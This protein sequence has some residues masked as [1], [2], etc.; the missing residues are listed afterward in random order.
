MR[1]YSPC[2]II[3]LAGGL[4][5]VGCQSIDRDSPPVLPAH[6]AKRIAPPSTTQPASAHSHLQPV[7]HIEPADEPPT[8]A[9]DHLLALA[10]ARN[11]DL[12]AAAARVDEARGRLAQAGLYP[13]P[14]VG[15][16]GNQIND[17]PGTPGQQGTYLTQEFVTAHKL[18]IA[19]EAARHGVSAADWRAA[20]QWYDTAARVKAAYVEYV[21]A[22]A[23]VHES[24][25]MAGLF[26]QGLA[27][28]DKLAAGGRVEAYDVTR[29]RVE[30]TQAQNRVGAAK[31]RAEA[32]ARML[33]IAVGV[34]RLPDEL[35]AQALTD[36][37]SV[38]GFDAAVHHAGHSS[39]VMAPLSELEQARVEQTLAEV[40]PVPNIQF[41]GV[42]AH[43]Y[44]TRAP[45]ASVTVGV[46]LPLFDRNQGNI[47]AA[48]ARVHA[49]GAAVEQARLK[50]IERL[51]TAY[52]KYLNALRQLDLYRTK[53]LPDATAA[54]EQI[55]R[56]Y[57]ARGERFFDTLDARRVLA[58]ARI[59]YAQSVGDLHAAAAEIEAVIQF[60][61]PK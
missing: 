9:L 52:Q 34:D 39:F 21:T 24:Q 40:K 1:R 7:T 60:G 30:L 37:G 32:A 26:E 57:A 18:K 43:D 25:R 49:A 11:P 12:T 61:R 15:Y 5:A 14:S 45:M 2:R 41:M 47:L 8:G 38:P 28:T 27:Q 31:Q 23:V 51:T 55:D 56:V 36:A 48:K 50:S 4:I 54:L 33:A 19:Q 10:R 6:L 17:G 35:P 53:I 3:F 20:S 58:Q 13:N 46:P 42:G 16:S 29:L 22:L 59:D 44:V